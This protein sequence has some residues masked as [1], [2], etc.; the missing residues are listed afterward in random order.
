[1]RR[2]INNL[3][4]IISSFFVSI[5]VSL[6]ILNVILRYVFNMG[7]Y[8]S[9][10]AATISFVWSVFIGAGAC[11]KKKM[12]IG[13]D[14]LTQL[15]SVKVQGIIHLLVNLALVGINGYITYLS[16]VFVR[17]SVG[18]PTAVLGISSAYMSAAVLAGFAIM[19]FHSIR[20]FIAG[21]KVLITGEV[22]K[23]VEEANIISK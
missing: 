21:V 20:F 2:I 15:A 3:E 5:T 18:K 13:I 10:E 12:H 1:M 6:V 17:A 22:N 23:E 9:E 4:E 7:I 8:W 16:I 19:T 11:Y 14:L